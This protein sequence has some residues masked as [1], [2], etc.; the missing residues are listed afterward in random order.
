MAGMRPA[1][2]LLGYL[3]ASPNTLLGLLFVP[4]AVLTGGRVRVVRGVVEVYGGAVRWFLARG[5]PEVLTLFG[6]AAAL[7][8]GHCVLAQDWDCAETSRDHEHV[9]VR[10]YARWGPLFLPAYFLCSFRC[11]RRGLDPYL[12]NPFERE[13][14]ERG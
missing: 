2:V 8:L 9:H 1:V 12:D 13:A 4:V 5:L 14:F 3:W 11:W 10:Q 7:T 6:P